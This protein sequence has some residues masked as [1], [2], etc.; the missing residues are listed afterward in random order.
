M[1]RDSTATNVA[2]SPHH[3]QN[4]AA[5]EP[6]Q[7]P[8]C[9]WCGAIVADPRKPH[10]YAPIPDCPGVGREMCTYG[11]SPWPI[12]APCCWACTPKHP[13]MIVCPDCGNK[14]C[15][16]ASDHRLPCSGSNEPGQPG[17][18]YSIRWTR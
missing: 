6:Q 1:S 10:P 7:S 14:R 11:N 17:S 18:I 2:H 13:G 3:L 15:P 9:P 4:T 16:R 5:S 12:E 8:P